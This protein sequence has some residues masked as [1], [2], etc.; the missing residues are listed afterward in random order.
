M[1]SLLLSLQSALPLY[2]SVKCCVGS[3]AQC[4]MSLTL[5][6]SFLALPHRM[7]HCFKCSIA[8]AEEMGPNGSPIPQA[9]SPFYRHC[10]HNWLCWYIVLYIVLR[11]SKLFQKSVQLVTHRL[12]LPRLGR[13]SPSAASPPSDA[14]P[15]SGTRL[16]SDHPLDRPSECHDLWDGLSA[17]PMRRWPAPR[18]LHWGTL[19]LPSTCPKGMKHA[20][21][22]FRSSTR[23]ERSVGCYYPL[24]P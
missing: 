21:I 9:C 12:C 18:A 7:T 23:R 13:A 8:C 15:G 11:R 17:L 24:A 1:V 2:L 6:P 3:A 14:S 16:S 20:A 10:S 5:K 19:S 22:Y 4:A